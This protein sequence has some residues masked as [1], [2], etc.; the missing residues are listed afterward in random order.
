MLVWRTGGWRFRTRLFFK[1]L[2]KTRSRLKAVTSDNNRGRIRI[3]PSPQQ[4]QHT[5]TCR[6]KSRNRELGTGKSSRIELTKQKTPRVKTSVFE[7]LSSLTKDN[8]NGNNGHGDKNDMWGRDNSPVLPG[9]L[10]LTS[11]SPFISSGRPYGI[12]LEQAA[13]SDSET[14]KETA[15]DYDCPRNVTKEPHK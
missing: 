4:R 7:A 8:G 10:L 15:M 2:T 6:M 3:W 9:N 12:H 11:S 1:L 5:S 14:Q 13:D